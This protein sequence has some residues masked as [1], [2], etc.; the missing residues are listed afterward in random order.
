MDRDAAGAAADVAR[1]EPLPCGE[2]HPGRRCRA[3]LEALTSGAGRHARG[4]RG[5]GLT[6]RQP[7][8]RPV[9]CRSLGVRRDRAVVAALPVP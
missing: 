5:R 8:V 4:L 9:E 2:L 6:R 1:A 3:C 7:R